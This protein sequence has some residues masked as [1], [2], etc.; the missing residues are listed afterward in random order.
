MGKWILIVVAVISSAGIWHF[1]NTRVDEKA[2][3]IAFVS[4]SNH[5][6]ISEKAKL[7]LSSIEA[8]SDSSS[9]PIQIF[10][11]QNDLDRAFL[12]ELPDDEGEEAVDP[13]LVELN[14]KS[15]EESRGFHDESTLL[16]YEAYSDSVLTSLI[17][18]GDIVAM[19]VLGE[20]M[21]EK[22]EHEKADALLFDAAASGS[23]SALYNKTDSANLFLDPDNR[24]SESDLKDS[25]KELF[26]EAELAALRGDLDSASGV[27]LFLKVGLNVGPL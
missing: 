4:T 13:Y 22:G 5:M 25:A 7:L 23:I 24:P 27:L 12:V 3:S 18:S 11:Q 1:S 14:T 19:E 20:R 16:A 9:R 15:W 10:D 26:I 17:G 6:N 21:R 8:S 2:P